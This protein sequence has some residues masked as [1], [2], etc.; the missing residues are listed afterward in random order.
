ME[1]QAI[2]EGKT[3]AFEEILERMHSEYA[4]LRS[5]R[6]STSLVDGLVVDYYGT[7]TPLGQ[8]ANVTVPEARQIVI[9]PWDKGML[10]PVEEAI[11]KSDLGISPSND[12]TLIRISLPPM[13]EENRKDLVKVLNQRTEEA[14]ISVRGVR[15]DIWKEIQQVEKDGGMSED[16]KFAGKDA[17]QKVIDRQ[18]EMIEEARKK[19]EAEIMTV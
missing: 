9:Q 14:R 7:P 8:A 2:I 16:D 10:E 5:G 12:G 4:K 18:N 13:T 1:Y 11:R 3:S 17:L 15:E 19:K 6:A